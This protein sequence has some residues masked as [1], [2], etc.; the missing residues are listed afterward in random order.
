MLEAFSRFLDLNL[1]Y[2]HF[3]RFLGIVPSGGVFFWITTSGGCSELPLE[4]LKVNVHQGRRGKKSF[5]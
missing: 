3:F 4:E 5:I 2:Q 1:Q